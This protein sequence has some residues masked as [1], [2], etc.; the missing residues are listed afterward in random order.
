M[1]LDDI[2][3]SDR[4]YANPYPQNLMRLAT[5]LGSDLKFSSL[6]IYFF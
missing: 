3:C 1:F 6:K 5:F 4:S 2:I